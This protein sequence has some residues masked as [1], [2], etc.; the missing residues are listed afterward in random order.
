MKMIRLILFVIFNIASTAVLAQFYFLENTTD[1]L[2]LEFLN[3]K[4]EI[5]PKQTFFNGVVIKNPSSRKVEFMS[6][7][8]YPADWTFIGEK[9]QRIILNPGDSIIVPF[10]AAAS[11]Q[12]KGEIGYS[13]VA[14]INDL[15]GNVIK[16][17]YSFVTIPKQKSIIFRPTAKVQYVN[18]QTNMAE[19]GLY[20]A[21]NG[22]I[23]EE[24][25]LLFSM[26]NIFEAL[27][28]VNG[29]YATDIILKPYTDTIFTLPLKYLPKNNI[30]KK[31]F[32]PVSVKVTNKDTV[33]NNLI[34]LKVLEPTYTNYK[35]DR[36]NFLEVELVANNVFNKNN[37]YYTGYINGN[38]LFKNN[39]D[40]NYNLK[41]YGTSFAEDPWKYGRY[42]ITYSTK[43]LQLQAGDI[44]QEMEQSTY[45]RGGKVYFTN[46]QNEATILTTRSVFV[47]RLTSAAQYVYKFNQK[48][49]AEIG[50]AFTDDQNIFSNE[51][52]AFAGFSAGTEKLGWLRYRLGVS[53][54]ELKNGEQTNSYLGLGMQA[55]YNYKYRNTIASI[56]VRYGQPEYS[57]YTKGKT[58]ITGEVITFLKENDFIKFYTD[59]N[60]SIPVSYTNGQLLSPIYLLSSEGRITYNKNISKNLLLEGGP[61]YVHKS[62]NGFYAY[63]SSIDF[64]TMG[65]YGYGRLLYRKGKATFNTILQGGYNLVS[66]YPQT[67]VDSLKAN[68]AIGKLALDDE[69]LS[70]KI[71]S[72]FKYSFF[73]L[74]LIYYN[75]PYAIP[76]EFRY[77]NSGYYY[78]AL[79]IFPYFSYFI[80]PD[81][82]QWIGS[83][84][85][86]YDISAKENRMMLSSEFLGYFGKGWRAGVLGTYNFQSSKDQITS[87][88][89]SYGA[90]YFELKVKKDFGVSQ[91]RYK[92]CNLDVYFFKDLNGNGIREKDEPGIKNVLFSIKVNEEELQNLEY[93][94]ASH[95]F[96]TELL[97]DLDGNVRY[98]NVPNGFY[99]IEYYPLAEMQGS[100]SAKESYQKIYIGKNEKLYIP[101]YENNKLFGKVVLNRSKLSNLGS[102]DVSNIKI[103]AEDTHGKKYSSLT[104]AQ[105]NFSI[106]V[107]SVDRYKVHVNNI[108]F[109]NFE[110]EQ[111]DYEVQLNGYKQFEVNF[112]FNEKKRKINFAQSYE[113]NSDIEGAGVEIV[114]RTNLTGTIKDA[115]S[116]SPL[117]ARIRILDEKG[118]EVNSTQSNPQTGLFLT[119]FIAGDNYT[120]EVTANDYWYMAEKLYSQQIVTFKNLQK[121]FL[122]K[123]IIVGALIPMR[124]LNFASGSYDIAPASFPELERLLK[125]LKA[126]PSVKIA[127]HGHADDLE[128]RD[129]PSLDIANERAKMVAR[130]L[131]AN[132]YNR[133]TYLGH[134]NSKP[135]ADNA[136][137]DGRRENRRVEIVVTGK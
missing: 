90:A 132:G 121:D 127:V 41:S 120:I 97:S 79:N 83:I 48:Y 66:D 50:G 18:R 2:T 6:K 11:V 59:I 46:K 105:G 40:L 10:R 23:D 69:W 101:F 70:L 16:N 123:G 22:N 116:L 95:F 77:F 3:K 42:Q 56:R 81:V 137:E 51:Y 88:T 117:Q 86:T 122:M 125:V 72:Y 82:L 98:E 61:M 114:R 85:Y 67:Y 73:N 35:P 119:S 27:G 47:N 21:N 133:V 7:F 89:S 32:N 4:L 57:G 65:Y 13:I 26:G 25:Y 12:T 52:S 60:Q 9:E 107:P 112:I 43:H 14:S 19:I 84:N 20:L 31:D 34:W 68:G 94:T 99:I 63:E 135:L 39:S 80:L 24:F 53:T 36:Y 1:Q 8:S 130:Y 126:N 109:E 110:L 87:Q 38:V 28:S 128:V 49:K 44:T 111:N 75:G 102:I 78:K 5:Q 76:Q 55:Y 64:G 115:T 33:I 108:F 106:Y 45:G 93:N 129:N 29:E 17:E 96:G 131:I 92:Y 113:Y 136:T 74:G 58:E 100:Y 91:P 134:A 124:T 62:S 118:N 37:A 15:N 30:T 71:T 104:D 54:I 103:T